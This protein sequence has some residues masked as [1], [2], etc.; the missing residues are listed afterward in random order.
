[1]G[2]RIQSII[3][4]VSTGI[5]FTVSWVI[6]IDG[7]L[8]THD[9]FPGTHILPSLFATLAAI[10]V[11][12]VTVKIVAEHTGGKVWLFFWITVQ[13]ICV[14]AA[15]FILSTE[16]PVDANYPG[17]SMLLQ[18]ILCMMASFVFFA[19]RSKTSEL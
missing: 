18:T 3:I 6:F 5:L 14:G 4:G 8:N 2:V 10:C 12:L 17:V 11:N 7:Q 15:I 16:Y 19:G 1:M 13:C 9:S